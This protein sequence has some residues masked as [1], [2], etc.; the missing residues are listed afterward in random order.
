MAPALVLMHIQRL[1]DDSLTSALRQG[2]WSHFGWG[3]DRHIFA[4]VYDA[5]AFNTEATGHFEKPPSLE[6]WPRPKTKKQ[7]AESEAPK[8]KRTVRDLFQQLKK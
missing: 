5:I 8:K 3:Q 2:G 7:A 4:D 1:P 6:R